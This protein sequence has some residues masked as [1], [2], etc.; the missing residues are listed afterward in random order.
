MGMESG[1]QTF[2]PGTSTDLVHPLI[3][4]DTLRHQ[5]TASPWAVKQNGRLS[6]YER[7]FCQSWEKECIKFFGKIKKDQ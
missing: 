3:N 1:D 7:K 4:R 5:Y 6:T 2:H